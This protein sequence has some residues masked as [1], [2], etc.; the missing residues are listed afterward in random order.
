MSNHPE[1][2]LLKVENLNVSYGAIHALKGIT[3]EVHKGEIVSL[4][5]ANG[6]GKTTT[7][8][9]LSGLVSSTGNILYKG[10]EISKVPTHERVTLGIAQSPE[11]RGVFFNL[12]VYE[13]LLMGAHFR[14]DKEIKSD[15]EMCYGLFPRLRER[16]TQLAGTLSGGE[17]QMLAISRALM[18]RPELL[19]LDEPSLGLAPIIVAQ[20][21]EI[22]LKLRS[23]GMTVL[24][25]EQNARM[26]LKISDRA[27]VI[28]TGTKTMEGKGSDLLH[29]DNVRKS[30]LGG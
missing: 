18:A 28:E 26:A 14:K 12:T 17:Q 21:F 30:Y 2:T 4:I 27:Y 13:N 25:V 19:L 10:Q 23:Q 8:R 15:I 1:Q 5:G 9:A 20:I 3:F 29:D 11:G 24:L 16:Q 22:I 7:M 6:A